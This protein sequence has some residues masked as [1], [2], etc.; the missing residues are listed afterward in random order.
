MRHNRLMIPV[1]ALALSF[2]T[3]LTT[4][5]FQTVGFVVGGHTTDQVRRNFIKPQGSM[6]QWYVA[7]NGNPAGKGTIELPWDLATALSGGPS[8]TEIKAGDTLWLRGGVYQGNFISTLTGTAEAPI[9]VRQYSGERAIIDRAS[10]SS[11]QQPAL[12]VKGPWVWFWGFEIMNSYPD[13]SRIDPYTGVLEPWRGSGA[14]V[15]AS[16][17]KFINMIFH[18]NGHGIW[19]KEDMT[20]VYGCLFYYNGNNKREH[21]MYVGNANGTKY[22]MDNIVFAQGGFGILSHSDSTSGS[23]KGLYIEGNASFNNGILTLDDQTAGNI[24]V[25]GVIGVSAERVILKNNYVYNPAGNATSKNAGIRLGYEDTSNKDLT[26][27]DN[28]IVSKVPLRVLWW[29]NV[30]SRGNTIYSQG[31]SL[32][33]IFPGGVGTSAY[34]WDLNT[35]LIG[36]KGGPNFIKDG[37]TYSF[38]GW[39]QATGLDSKSLVEQNISLR[40]S[41]MKIFLRPNRYEPGRANIVVYNWDLQSS[42][43]VDMNSVLARGASYEVRDAENYFGEPVARGTYDGTPI[44][45]P[46]NMTQVTKPVGNVE[47]VPSHTAPEFAV[48][49]LRAIP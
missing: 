41:G 9:V 6:A 13:R 28:Y 47:R 19:D 18:D 20:E 24:Q 27:L 40:P 3:A 42:V 38:T 5:Y 26:L 12:K 39:Q 8:R 36:R 15:Y 16:N 25:G 4:V 43:A 17:V 35:Y 33:L 23:Q 48:F 37:S 22:I 31:S 29:Q 34:R 10:V 30:E 2:I 44:K 32:D 14:D 21:A 1:S 7:P 49:V 11:A 45:L 46:M